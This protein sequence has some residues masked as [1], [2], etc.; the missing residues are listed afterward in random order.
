MTKPG[1]LVYRQNLLDL[2]RVLNLQPK[3][4]GAKHFT[5]KLPSCQTKIKKYIAIF[6]NGIK[7]IHNI[8]FHN[9]P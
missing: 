8:D 6:S 2:A 3:E 1:A 4:R 9:F 7:R 5:T